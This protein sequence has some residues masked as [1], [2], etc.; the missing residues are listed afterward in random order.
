MSER[1]LLIR[2]ISNPDDFYRDEKS[3]FAENFGFTD[4]SSEIL[5]GRNDK[6]WC[7]RSIT[8]LIGPKGGL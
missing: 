6:E 5:R 2:V 8:N 7:F 1:K 3:G 4:F